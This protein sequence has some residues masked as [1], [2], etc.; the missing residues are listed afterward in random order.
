[1]NTRKSLPILAL[2]IASI[3][4][5]AQEHDVVILGGRV[6]DPETN[7]DQIANVGINGGWITTIT[8]EAITGK[9]T[10]DAKGLVVGPGF[11]DTEQ[12]GLSE[13]GFKVNL[14]DG[15]TTQ[16]DFEVG[17]LN[18]SEWYDARKGKLQANYGTV[19]SHEFARMRVHDK[20]ELK[21]P[22]ISM[23]H[24]FALRAQAAEDGVNGWSVTKSTTEQMNAITQILDE[25]L[26]EGALG[27]GST[28]GYA[29][30]GITTYEM[31]EAQRAAARYGR[32]TAVHHRFHPSASTPT[33]TPTGANEI[34]VNAML[35]DAPLEIHHTNDYGWWEIEEKTQL[36]RKKG[37]NIWSTWY[38][39][40]AGSGN[41]GATI[42]APETWEKAMGYKYEETIYDPLNDKFLT[43]DEFLKLAKED[44]AY[45]L[46]AFS[47]P[48][49]EWINEWIKLPH[50]T[51]SGDG[52]PTINAKGEPLTWDSP[53]EEYAGH[54]RTAG[55]HAKVLKLGR[56]AELPLT[57]SLSQLSYWPAKHLGDAGIKAM[58]VRG[59]M[60]E[61]KVADITIFDPEKVTDNATYKIGEQGL[62][63][64]G[65]PYVL[66]FGTL[67]VKDSKVLKGVT[68]GQPIRFPVEEEGRFVPA[69]KKMWLQQHTIDSSGIAPKGGANETGAANGNTSFVPSPAPLD[70]GDDAYNQLF[71]PMNY[72]SV[73]CCKNPYDVR[74]GVRAALAA[75][76]LPIQLHPVPLR[77]VS[78]D[79][80]DP[81]SAAAIKAN[82]N[83]KEAIG[84]SGN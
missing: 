66:V 65:I 19:A 22:E 35:L 51:V 17:A 2:V 11:I 3:A 4:A 16:M 47:P 55:S 63:S 1:M 72:V 75:H 29:Q 5:Q 40:D 62:P 52:M 57:H 25:G 10:I 61:G 12:H 56:E 15:V 45:A 13:F 54:P 74:L 77:P 20:L 81:L 41:A 39:Y 31:L 37:Y 14:R 49:R 82:R 18:I 23:P 8:E 79:P 28:V 33:E 59:R 78:T 6:I 21:G 68:P 27:V 44:P 50:F 9:E 24:L 43:K 42:L 30:K 83:R 36:A 73:A 32:L 71:G 60:Q 67:V 70:F 26:R 46:V 64:T 84:A 53:Y 34:I 7:F 80:F 58:Q 69:S 76:F 48:R 38:P